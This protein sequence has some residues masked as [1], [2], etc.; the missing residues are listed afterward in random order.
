[1]GVCALGW[2][3]WAGFCRCLSSGAVGAGFGVGVGDK[4]GEGFGEV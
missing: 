4:G 2:L 1:V 3:L